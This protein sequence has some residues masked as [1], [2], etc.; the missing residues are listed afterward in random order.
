M[1]PDE[2]NSEKRLSESQEKEIINFVETKINQLI[3]EFF[4]FPFSFRVEEDLRARLYTLL[5]EKSLLIKNIERKG[6]TGEDEN[7]YDHLLHLENDE[8]DK[9][10]LV[11]YEPHNFGKEETYLI[12]VE[13]KTNHPIYGRDSLEKD[14]NKLNDKISRIKYGYFLYF[15]NYKEL[16]KGQKERLGKI[17]LKDNMVLY[18]NSY[19]DKIK[20][21]KKSNQKWIKNGI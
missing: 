8:E 12:A 6:D 11:V 16:E 15:R 20:W 17:T 9:I 14:I 7:V 1:Q 18:I 4:K 21:K 13:I 2:L 10:D 19:K 3:D 5:C